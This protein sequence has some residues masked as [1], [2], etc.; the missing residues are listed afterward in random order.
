M[1]GAA[2]HP[3]ALLLGWSELAES[4]TEAFVEFHNREHM[5]E[6]FAIPGFLRAARYVAVEN[7]TTFLTV[8]DIDG[9]TTLTSAAYLERLDNPTPW[10]ME[11]LPKISGGRRTTAKIDYCEGSGRGGHIL[12]A[13][14]AGLVDETQRS[15][16]QTVLGLAIGCGGIV[17]IKAGPVDLQSSSVETA[18][19]RISQRVAPSHGYLAI[20]EATSAGALQAVDRSLIRAA[21]PLPPPRVGIYRLEASL[22]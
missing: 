20:L 8:Y 13:E 15:A 9:I 14:W 2:D 17:S 5:P 18:E 10:T 22:G 4:D 3:G 7:S 1:S 12:C 11:T 16:L 19:S 6:R 21:R